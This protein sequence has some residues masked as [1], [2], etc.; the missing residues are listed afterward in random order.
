MALALPRRFVLTSANRHTR[1]APQR[2]GRRRGFLR[3]NWKMRIV[4]ACILL[5]ACLFAWAALARNLAPTGNTARDRFDA[6][7]VLGYPADSDGNPTPTQLERV[8]EAVR[9]YERGVPPQLIVTGGAAANHTV[10]PQVMAR[11]AEAQGVPASK[12]IIE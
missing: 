1:K 3:P 11:A 12:V 10:E 2:R 9:E 6:I 8:T 7:I 4:V 5:I